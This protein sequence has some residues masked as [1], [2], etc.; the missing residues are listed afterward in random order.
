MLPDVTRLPGEGLAPQQLRFRRDAQHRPRR[1]IRDDRGTAGRIC[2]AGSRAKRVV[3]RRSLR[4]GAGQKRPGKRP[5]S[6]SHH[7]A[8]EAGQTEMFRCCEAGEVKRP[9]RCAWRQ[10]PYPWGRDPS[11]CSAVSRATGQQKNPHRSLRPGTGQKRPGKRPNKYVPP[12]GKRVVFLRS[13]RPGVSVP[14]LRSGRQDG[15]PPQPEV[16]IKEGAA[17]AL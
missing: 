15:N 5:D 4:P 13:L 12:R 14:P 3:F 17:P 2:S 8:D 6:V 9:G 7:G 16:D 1:R 11:I 10:L